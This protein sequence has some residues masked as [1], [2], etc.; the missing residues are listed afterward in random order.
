MQ[1]IYSLAERSGKGRRQN[2]SVTRALFEEARNRVNSMALI[3][4]RMYRSADLAH[5]DFK[6]YLQSLVYG[7]ADSYDRRDVTLSVD[8]EPLALNVN[9]GIPC[10]LIV[11]ELVS[12]CLKHAFP[13]GRTGKIRLGI[14]KNSETA[15]SCSLRTTASAS[16]DVDFATRRSACNC[17]GAGRAI[18]GRSSARMGRERSASRSGRTGKDT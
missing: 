10:G 6:D 8:M 18:H 4:E 7:I 14:R 9:V 1:V 3:H 16:A 17:S 15:M 13:G 12:N 5:I 2:R 11:N